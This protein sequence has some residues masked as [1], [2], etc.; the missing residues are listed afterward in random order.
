MP[1]PEPRGADI[2]AMGLAASLQS[3]DA[4]TKLTRLDTSSDADAGG[5]DPASEAPVYWL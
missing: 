3:T 1:P 2:D 5:M 4:A